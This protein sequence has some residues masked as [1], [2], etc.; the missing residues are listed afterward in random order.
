MRLEEYLK[1]NRQ[2]DPPVG[3][4]GVESDWMEVGTL[5]VTTGS[6]WAGD[7]FVCNAEDGCVAK[8]P[9]GLYALEAKAMDFAARKRVSR[10]RVYLRGAREPVVGKKMGTTLTDTG[11][12]AVC[13]IDA[14]DKA[15]GGDYDRF[16]D[17]VTQRDY[18]DCG[19]VQIQMKGPIVIH[20]VSTGF[21]DCD[22]PVYELKSGRTRI[23]MELEFLAPGYVFQDFEDEDEEEDDG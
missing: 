1:K 3:T 21:G 23:G 4:P 8:V 10:L 2:S 19:I 6:L 15:V 14:L 12:M 7:P 22:A 5:E 20:Y 18:K 9:A 17:L 13:D 16:N 11:M